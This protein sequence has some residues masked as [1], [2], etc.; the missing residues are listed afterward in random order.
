MLKTTIAAATAASLLLTSAALAQARPE[1]QVIVLHNSA[2]KEAGG[3]M[4]VDAPK[5]VLLRV[6]AKG[7]T[8]G[9]HGVHFHDKGDCSKADFTSAGAHVHGADKAAHGLLNPAANET[10]DLPNLFIGKDGSGMA[11]FYT[12]L[13]TLSALHDADGSAL[14]VHASPDDHSTQP[15]GGAGARVA[16]GVIR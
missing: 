9:W 1:G 13:T 5:G 4:L 6:S 16:C 14:V 11:E 15:I 7:L 10:G 12:T 3:V 8:P 2:G